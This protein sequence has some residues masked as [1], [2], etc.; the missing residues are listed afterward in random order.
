MSQ[1]FANTAASRPQVYVA[2]Q[3]QLKSASYR[4]AGGAGSTAQLSSRIHARGPRS[5]ESQRSGFRFSDDGCQRSSI[6]ANETPSTSPARSLEQGRLAIEQIVADLSCSISGAVNQRRHS[7]ARSEQRG[8]RLRHVPLFEH[9][10]TQ[11][12]KG[13]GIQHG[14]QHLQGPT[15]NGLELPLRRRLPYEDVRQ[16]GTQKV[17][18]NCRILI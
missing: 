12:I 5:S 17:R 7:R 9:G 14:G 11:R 4:S 15:L 10:R 16:L 6:C 2:R 8:A 1:Q 13:H 3:R 18:M